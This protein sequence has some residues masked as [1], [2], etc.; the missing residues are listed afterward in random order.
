MRK[1]I[2]FLT[3]ASILG[4]TLLSGPVSAETVLS[5]S[6]GTDCT[7]TLREDGTLTITG[8]GKID[9]CR[10]WSDAP[11]SAVCGD[12]SRIVVEDGIT[13]IGNSAFECCWGR[14][15][16]K[17]QHRSDPSAIARS[18]AAHRFRRS[19]CRMVWRT[20]RRMHSM[21]VTL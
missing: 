8:T 14:N 15:R 18:M 4:C 11:W 7:W 1:Q 3:A 16:L 5:G 9:D 2:A 20:F 6:C 17:L 13:A 21:A 10:Y 19:H 12:V